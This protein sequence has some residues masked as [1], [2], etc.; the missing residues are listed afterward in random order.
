MKK[1]VLFITSG[2]CKGG[3][4]TQLV[5]IALFLKSIDYTV[6]I[7]S[8]TPI[9]EFDID[10]EKEGIPVLFLKSWKWSPVSNSRL[11]YKTV[12]EYQPDVVIA[13]MFIAI[14]FARLLKKSLQFKL[15]SSIRIAVLTKKWYIPF[16][17]TSGLDDAIVYNSMASKLNFEDN[18]LV[19]KKGIVINNGISIP[20]L[21]NL[22]NFR[23][24]KGKF[25]WVCI[26]HFRWNKD[27]N[28]L[29]RAI[30]ILK[31]LNFR[32]DII[33]EYN[34]HNNPFKI[35]KDLKI[36]EHVNI[37]GFKQNAAHYLEYADAFVLSSFSEGMP[38][39]LL[40]AM[41]YKKPVVVTNIDCNKEVLQSSECGLLF[42]KENDHDLAIKMLNMMNMSVYERNA[43]GE[44]GRT[45]IQK[46]FAEESVMN[47]WLNI[48]KQH[49]SGQE[50]IL[51]EA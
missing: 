50:L 49:S 6:R 23:L 40:E 33:G 39:A 29:F 15:I 37:L 25:V 38:N 36:E 22:V 1:K 7:I 11:L 5:K 18:G 30:A 8:L 9:N 2:M 24:P 14:I 4:E 10:Y 42:E 44:K 27:Y 20:E 16:R 13:F 17:A 3:A 46:N 21:K 26:A 45:Y 19:S 35:I 28:T 34:Q 51:N 43:F 48:I 47:S 31:G 12:K 32:V 41:A